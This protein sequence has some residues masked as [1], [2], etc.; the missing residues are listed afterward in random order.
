LGTHTSGLICQVVTLD[1]LNIENSSRGEN[2]VDFCQ[3][4][5]VDKW[6]LGQV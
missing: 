2:V 3:V 5:S 6:S 1:R 4:I